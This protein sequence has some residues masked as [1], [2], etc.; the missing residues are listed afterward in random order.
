MRT[1]ETKARVEPGG[2]IEVPVPGDVPAGQYRVV[3]TLE[4]EADRG[5]P[6]DPPFPVDD[7]G[8][9]PAGLTLRRDELYDD[10]GR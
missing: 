7:L 5:L 10:A 8:P 1:I 4:S 2:T 9:W 3:V 6:G